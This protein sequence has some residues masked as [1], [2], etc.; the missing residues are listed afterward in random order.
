MDKV[1]RKPG[2]KYTHELM[3]DKLDEIVDWISAHECSC[4]EKPP[5]CEPIIAD[6][7]KRLRDIESQQ[8]PSSIEQELESGLEHIGSYWH[9]R[10]KDK[11][12]PVTRIFLPA[13]KYEEFIKYGFSNA[14][15]WNENTIGRLF[16]DISVFSYSG[17]TIVYCT[18]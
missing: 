3:I 6:I 14:I 5:P 18:D 12:R 16:H 11:R 1:S 7:N 9:R 15:R 2:T 4:V 8:R 13:A 17:E 10:T